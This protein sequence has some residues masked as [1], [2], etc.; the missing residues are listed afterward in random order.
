MS[1][2]HRNIGIYHELLTVLFRKNPSFFNFEKI[3]MI[4]ELVSNGLN[5]EEVGNKQ[6]Y[7]SYNL[8]IFHGLILEKEI[9]LDEG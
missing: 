7:L 6:C 8:L 2:Y 5:F 9:I 3:R 1:D 4:I